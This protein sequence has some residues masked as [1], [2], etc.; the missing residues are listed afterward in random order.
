MLYFNLNLTFFL[1]SL[2]SR[3]KFEWIRC[4]PIRCRWILRLRL[5]AS[6]R[7]TGGVNLNEMNRL[8]W[9]ELILERREIR[10]PEVYEVLS[11]GKLFNCENS[12]NTGPHRMKWTET[13][14]LHYWNWNNPGI[15]TP[16][17]QMYYFT[18]PAMRKTGSIRLRET[19]Q[20]REK[21]QAGLSSSR[22]WRN[23]S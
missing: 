1:R 17:E 8:F 21:L 11:L 9:L 23:R 13:N 15:N 10:N 18:S 6:R 20:D 3:L 7:M 16:H 12:K 22:D 5:E 14:S 4:K 2:L 19:F